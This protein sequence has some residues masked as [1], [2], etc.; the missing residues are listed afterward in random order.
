MFGAPDAVLLP[1][2]TRRFFRVAMKHIVSMY[3]ALAHPAPPIAPAPH[4]PGRFYVGA[5]TADVVCDGH[6]DPVAEF[7]SG[8]RGFRLRAP[9]VDGAGLVPVRGEGDCLAPILRDG[10]I[11]FFDPTLPARDGDI[12]LVAYRADDARQAFGDNW[13]GHLLFTKLLRHVFG[14]ALL[15]TAEGAGPLTP[16][17]TILGVCRR[18]ERDGKSLY[19]E[20]LQ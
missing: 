3:P 15:L 14:H 13:G 5:P 20:H 11:C 16:R 1:C 10:D 6:F 9:S 18:I 12:V 19:T 7:A 8:A 17:Q 4:P 2:A